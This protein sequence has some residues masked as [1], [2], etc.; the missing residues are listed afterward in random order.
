M[1]FGV[2][3]IGPSLAPEFNALDVI[4]TTVDG[5]LIKAYC[6]T[7]NDKD[8]VCPNFK[9]KLA[10]GCSNYVWAAKVWLEKERKGR[11]D[12]SAAAV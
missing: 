12:A 10:A 4:L 6:G 11:K 8:E 2:P 7:F 1:H 5:H 9:D 3:N